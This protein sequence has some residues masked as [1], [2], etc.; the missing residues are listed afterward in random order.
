[1]RSLIYDQIR[2]N[3]SHTNAC[4]NTG[5]RAQSTF[6]MKFLGYAED[7][8]TCVRGVVS[9]GDPGYDETA[10]MVSARVHVGNKCDELKERLPVY[11]VGC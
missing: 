8:K 2:E 5:T 6:E 9:G 10:K 7:G 4:S 11:P 1:M 3:H